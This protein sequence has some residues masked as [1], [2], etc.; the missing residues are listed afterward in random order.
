MSCRDGSNCTGQRLSNHKTRF[1]LARMRL[2]FLSVVR[3]RLNFL[4]V[5]GVASY[6]RV[7]CLNNLLQRLRH[8]EKQVFTH[9]GFHHKTDSTGL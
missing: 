1:I 4:S 2:N 9:E 7:Q 5:Q 6:L 8:L 3:M